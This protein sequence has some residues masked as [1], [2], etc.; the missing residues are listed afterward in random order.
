MS[1]R[2]AVR[3][4]DS[5]FN[6][7]PLEVAEQIVTSYIDTI[8]KDFSNVPRS[9]RTKRVFQQRLKTIYIVSPSDCQKPRRKLVVEGQARLMW[10]GKSSEMRQ[11]AQPLPVSSVQITK[12]S[13]TEHRLSTEV[14]AC[15]KILDGKSRKSGGNPLC[16]PLRHVWGVCWS[17]ARAN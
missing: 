10:S 7:L 4:D 1:Q 11:T 8:I 2:V 17:L 9:A 12:P 14:L 15:I 13:Y 3:T 16:S 6:F 5:V